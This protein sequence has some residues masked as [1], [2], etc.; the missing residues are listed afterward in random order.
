MNLPTAIILAA[1]IVGAAI[2][3]TQRYELVPAQNGPV[4]WRVDI[5]TGETH[6]CLGPG[7]C[8]RVEYRP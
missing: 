7:P 5:L 3:W 8:T 1:V 2:V 4:M 6:Y